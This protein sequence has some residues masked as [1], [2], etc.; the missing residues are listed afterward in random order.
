MRARLALLIAGGLLIGACLGLLLIPGA[1]ERLLPKGGV[2]SIGRATVGGPFSLV[3]HTGKRVTDQDFR[4]RFMLVFFGFTFCPDVCP[5]AL[6]V[7]GAALDKLGDKAARVTPVLISVDPERDTPEQLKSYVSSFHPRLVGLTG[8]VAEIEAVARAY[9]AY[10]RKVKD[11]RSTAGYSIDHTS[12]IYLMGP[13]GS[14]I[15]HFTHAS[16]VD[17][18]ASGL[19]KHL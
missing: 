15:T 19:A 12:I 5:T 4:G 6:Q 3:D 17:A 18:M 1:L 2:P 9:R 11:E 10:H 16:S 13:D 7:S 8:T 14:F